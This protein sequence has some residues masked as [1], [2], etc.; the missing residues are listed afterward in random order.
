MVCNGFHKSFTIDH[1]FRSTSF[2]RCSA[3]Y[4]SLRLSRK[5]ALKK[6][7]IMST[8]IRSLLVA[9]ALFGTVSAASA[10]TRNSDY[11]YGNQSGFNPTTFFD[12]LQRNAG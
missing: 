8:I 7:I 9:A 6:E 4:L 10:V 11:N 3:S 1:A 5:P 2:L 12:D